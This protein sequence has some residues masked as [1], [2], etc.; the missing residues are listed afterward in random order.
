MWKDPD[1]IG[2][3][4]RRVP[5]HLAVDLERR[6]IDSEEFGRMAHLARRRGVETAKV[7]MRQQCDLWDEPE[8]AHMSGR[9][10]G[11]LGDLIGSRV[12]PDLCVGKKIGPARR[13]DERERGEITNPGSMADEVADVLQMAEKA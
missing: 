10:Y 5:V 7:R 12:G 9:Q 6:I 3:T 1:A 13:D 11:H 2:R 4:Q 8:P